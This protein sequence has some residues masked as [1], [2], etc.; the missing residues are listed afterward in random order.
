MHQ[1]RIG[2]LQDP[3]LQPTHYQTSLKYPIQYLNFLPFLLSLI[4]LFH[5]RADHSQNLHLSQY[6]IP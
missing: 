2:H 3:Q 6:P 5:E 4:F 1:N